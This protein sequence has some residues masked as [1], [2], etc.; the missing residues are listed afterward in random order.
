MLAPVLNVELQQV[1]VCDAAHRPSKYQGHF[2]SVQAEILLALPHGAVLLD[3][4]CPKAAIRLG[5]NFPEADSTATNLV[6]SLMDDCTPG[7]QRQTI[8]GTFVGKLTYSEEGRLELRLISVTQIG[9]QSCRPGAPVLLWT[10]S[11]PQLW[12]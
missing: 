12:K 7:P 3:H 10:P 8:P 1:S 11:P 4:T 2:V 6:P 5:V 9:V